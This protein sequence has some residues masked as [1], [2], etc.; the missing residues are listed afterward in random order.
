MIKIVKW[1]DSK[2]VVY[3]SKKETIREAVMEAVM[4]KVNLRGSNLSDSDLRGSDLSDSNLMHVKFYGRGGTT[5]IKK[6][7]IAQFHE[8]LGI[9]VEDDDKS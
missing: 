1:Y 3:E 2:S 7:Q 9:V 5:R 8:A 6:S 4:R